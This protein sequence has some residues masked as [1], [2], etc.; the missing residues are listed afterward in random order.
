MCNYKTSLINFVTGCLL[1]LMPSQSSSQDFERI[2]IQQV[3]L[4]PV[5]PARYARSFRDMNGDIHVMGIFKVTPDNQG[6]FITQVQYNP[7]FPPTALNE[8]IMNTFFS[9]PGYFIALNNRLEFK[10]KNTYTTKMWLSVNN[11]KTLEETEATF[12]LPEA[13]NV[14]F[15][16]RDEWSGLFCHRSVLQLPD[17]SLLASMYGNFE[18]DT[19]TPVNPQSKSETKFMLRAF[20]VHSTDSGFTW[21]YR[22]T[23]AAPN[24]LWFE[25]SEGFNEW[26]MVQLDNGHLLAV[27]RTGHYTPL[28]FCISKDL[29][30]TWSAPVT[31]PETFPAGC[32]PC[33]IKLDDGRVALAFGE[34]V[35]PA[36]ASAFEGPLENHDRRRRCRL[37]ISK[38]PEAD[39]WQVY[40]ITGYDN[41]S[42]YPTIFQAL[43]NTILYQSDLELYQIQIPNQN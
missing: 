28:V 1:F 39:S 16:N 7:V 19:I 10:E 29:G 20:V 36:G 3:S 43:P 24:T 38:T 22:S 30:K 21:H 37:A 18:P 31:Y 9:K 42:A 26:S 4:D 23:L 11:L 2:N 32:D 25:N 12:S 27:I 35:Q 14:D 33:L 40:N 41:R 13:G 15:G 34:M 5:R 8:A 6:R 17:G